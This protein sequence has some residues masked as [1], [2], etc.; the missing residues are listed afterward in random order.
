MLR[1]VRL[2]CRKQRM[3]SQKH[4]PIRPPASMARMVMSGKLMQVQ[5]VTL[6]VTSAAS[7][8]SIR[9]RKKLTG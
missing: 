6:R 1:S 4:R 3:L 7:A 8:V 2:N 5:F 9:N